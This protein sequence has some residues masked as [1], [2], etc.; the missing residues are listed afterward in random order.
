MTD[1]APRPAPPPLWA[2]AA[3]VLA[4]A[5]A[6][7]GAFV[8]FSGGFRFQVAGL[9]VSVTSGTRIL[10]IAAAIVVLRVL[11]CRRPSDFG[12]L[13]S[14]VKSTW[15]S[16][17]LRAVVPVWAASRFGVLAVG[18]FAMGAFGF[19][20]YEVPFKV[21]QTEILNLPAR[22]DA[23][24]YLDVAASGYVWDPGT[25]AQQNIAFMPALP[26]LMRVGGRLIG[27]HP[28]WAGQILVLAASL[29]GFVYV[30]RLARSALGDEG[31]AAAAVALLAAYPF[32]VF[33]SAVYTESIFLLGAAGAFHHVTRREYWRVAAFSLLCG[34]TRPNGFL[35]ALPVSLI[36]F[37]PAF[38]EAKASAGSPGLGSRVT[39]ALRAAA[40]AMLA[41]SAAV[42]GVLAFS[43]FVM[44]LTGRPL[45]WL[46]AHGAWGRVFGAWLSDGP[47]QELQYRGLY[48]FVRTRPIDALNL[49]AALGGLAAIWPVTKRL[50]AAYGV[51][52]AIVLVPPLAAGGLLSIGRLT[53]VMFPVFIW[54][55]AAVPARHRAAWLAA[56][57]L[58]QG[59]GASLFFTLREFI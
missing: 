33:Y 55:A 16:P 52:V 56:F 43:G 51:F 38:V 17:S 42:A 5:V 37:W 2:R 57:A 25:T 35:I 29:W 18:I 36:V 23:G 49:A 47:I 22:Y 40:P 26:L 58:F 14:R 12:A 28:L 45:A 6:A 19:R 44:A 21:Y 20:Q 10:A 59:W 7:A 13:G 46:E 1:H 11:F 39:R 27:G 34:L 48:G 24:W 4:A 54:L 8:A 31:Q 53:S 32:A 3:D 15:R 30:F 50:G 41:S 9:R